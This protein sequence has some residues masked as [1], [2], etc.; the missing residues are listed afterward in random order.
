MEARDLQLISLLI[1]ENDE[2][3]KLWQEHLR[4]ERALEKLEGKRYLNPQEAQE[5]KRLQLAKLS[6]KTRIELILSKTRRPLSS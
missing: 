6:G 2:L 4:F 3:R 1:Q 5:K